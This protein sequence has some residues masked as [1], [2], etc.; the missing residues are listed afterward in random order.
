MEFTDPSATERRSHWL[1]LVTLA[2]ALLAG[3]GLRLVWVDD[4]E[5]KAD[6]V[7]TFQ[8]TQQAGRTAAFPWRGM[9]SSHGME[10]PGL[11]V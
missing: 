4:M 9:P 1:A 2:W 10:N 3:A 6:E 8:Q 11:S 5:F 7:W